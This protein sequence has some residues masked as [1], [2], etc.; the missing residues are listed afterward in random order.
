MATRRANNR[1]RSAN[2]G[3]VLRHSRGPR[4]CAI[5][6]FTLSLLEGVR[7]NGQPTTTILA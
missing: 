3:I 4:G 5:E 6:G 7:G 1:A 2:G